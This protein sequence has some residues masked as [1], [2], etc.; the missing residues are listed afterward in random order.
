MLKFQRSNYRARHSASV[1]TKRNLIRAIG[2]FVAPG[3]SPALRGLITS[4]V[5][6]VRSDSTDVL[7]YEQPVL[8][9]V[10]TLKCISYIGT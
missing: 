5:L 9:S 8:Q 4:V 1:N 3:G 10:P 2:P 7:N 6:I